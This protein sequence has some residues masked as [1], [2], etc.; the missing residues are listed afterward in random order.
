M[1]GEDM[2]FYN[3]SLVTCRD[4]SGSVKRTPNASWNEKRKR[5]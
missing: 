5:K 2:D 4:L 1:Y 3:R